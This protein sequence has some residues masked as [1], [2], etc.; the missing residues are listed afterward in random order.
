MDKKLG[1][2]THTLKKKVSLSCTENAAIDFFFHSAGIDVF[3]YHVSSTDW[4]IS[5]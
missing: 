2:N 3:K 4:K 5:V 1:K